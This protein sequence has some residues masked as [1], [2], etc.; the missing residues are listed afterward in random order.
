MKGQ[1]VTPVDI[2]EAESRLLRP[3]RAFRGGHSA[4]AVA[5]F[6]PANDPSA[7]ARARID[8]A[9]LSATAAW[10]DDSARRGLR[11]LARLRLHRRLR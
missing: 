5:A 6:T 3:M 1:N 8:D 4:T 11:R 9:E 10:A 7:D 2:G